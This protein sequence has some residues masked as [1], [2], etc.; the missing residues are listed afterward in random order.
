MV[1]TFDFDNTIAMSHMIITPDE[2]V[3]YKFEGYNGEIVKKIRQHIQNGDDVHIVTSRTKEKEHQMMGFDDSIEKH[4]GRLNL[5]GYFLPHNLHYTNG[6]LKLNKL[7]QIGSEMHWDDDIEEMISLKSAGMGYK[8]PLDL[9]PESNIVAKVLIFDSEDNLLILQRGDDDNLWDIPGGHLKQVEEMRGKDGL[10][11]GAER[12]VAEETGIIL[13]FQK[14]IGVVPITWK[15]KS[16][17]VYMFMSKL[18]QIKPEINLNL[19]EK[20]ENIAFEWVTLQELEEFLAHSTKILR[21]AAEILPKNELF[22]QNEPFQLTKRRGHRKMKKK[23]IGLGGNKHTGGGKGHKKPSYKRSKSA[24]A[25]IGV[26]EEENDDI[27]HK[28]RV[29]ITSMEAK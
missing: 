29:K 2:D 6:Q 19:Q 8:S 10:E 11:E 9:L 5:Q 18:K 1:V 25:P 16:N 27:K 21:K 17:E 26:L 22:E 20:Q 14:Q 3:E 13:P 12:E 23:L 28:I 7:R 15:G 4:L 24:P